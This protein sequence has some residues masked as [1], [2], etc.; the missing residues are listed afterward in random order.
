VRPLRRI[1]GTASPGSSSRTPA[2]ADRVRDL[3]RSDIGDRDATRGDAVT[4]E[5]RRHPR[6]ASVM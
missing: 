6:A 5:R 1:R 2:V 3:T 4:D